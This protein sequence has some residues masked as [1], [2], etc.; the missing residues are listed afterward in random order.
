ML[1][2]PLLGLQAPAAGQTALPA[3][4]DRRPVLQ[5]LDGAMKDGAAKKIVQRPSLDRPVGQLLPRCTSRPPSRRKS[6]EPTCHID[7]DTEV[8]ESI[9]DAM[10]LAA[11][12]VKNG[13]QHVLLQKSRPQERDRLVHLDLMDSRLPSKSNSLLLHKLGRPKTM[14]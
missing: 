14:E 4:P 7:S 10:L 3:K 8:P 13:G 11:K 1:S 12:E 2:T 6:E 9:F 5:A